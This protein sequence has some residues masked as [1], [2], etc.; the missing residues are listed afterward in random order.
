MYVAR[1]GSYG[2]ATDLLLVNTNGFTPEDYESL[3]GVDDGYRMEE[4]A[5]IGVYRMAEPVVWAWMTEN[6]AAQVLDTLETAIGIAIKTGNIGL[7]ESLGDVR[8]VL[9]RSGIE[10]D[11]YISG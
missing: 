3:D 7:A 1:D 5:E 6:E 8:D 9:N 2:D 11:A 10:R 4:A